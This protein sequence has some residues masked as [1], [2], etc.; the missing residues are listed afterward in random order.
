MSSQQNDPRWW[1]R[2]TGKAKRRQTSTTSTRQK[3]KSIKKTHREKLVILEEQI[4]ELI[5]KSQ[6][7]TFCHWPVVSQ[8]SLGTPVSFWAIC[9]IPK[10]RST[11][12]DFTEV[13]GSW[14]NCWCE[15]SRKNLSNSL[16]VPSLSRV[17]LLVTPWT[18]ARQ[19]SLSITNS[20]SLLKLMS[21]ES[22]MPPEWIIAAQ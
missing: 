6:T 19:A 8:K 14:M 13:L 1:K 7:Q 2:D 17:R 3:L 21:I 9:F 5:R 18:A 10:S 20:W 15:H 12:G 16:K 11:T 22:V 4:I